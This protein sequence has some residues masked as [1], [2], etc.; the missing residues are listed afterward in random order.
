MD[1]PTVLLVDSHEDSLTIY[2]VILEHHG[3]RVLAAARWDEG[4]RLAREGRP[5]LIF[6]E[7]S[8]VGGGGPEAARRLKT[9][10][11]TAAVPIVALSTAFEADRDTALEAGFAG[12]LL[13]PCPPLALLAEAV[14]HLGRPSRS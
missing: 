4:L 1:A 10:R 9:A 8:R 14:R 6:L 3:F 13:K 12:Y 11:Q 7:Y 5:D 2:R